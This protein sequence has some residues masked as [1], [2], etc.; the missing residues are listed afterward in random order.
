[1]DDNSG[2][3][4]TAI[5]DDRRRPSMPRAI[6]G[7]IQAGVLDAELTALISTMTEHGLPLVVA[8]ASDERSSGCT[9]HEISEAIGRALAAVALPATAGLGRPPVSIDA[10]SLESVL[11]RLP[12][13]AL[14]S[15]DDSGARV[16]VVVVLGIDP[17][18]GAWR[19]TAAHLLRPPLRDGQGHVQRQ[20]PAVLA[21]WDPERRRFEHFS[22]AVL[23]EVGQLVGC[24]AGDLEAEIAA[25]TDLL[26]GLAAHRVEDPG[27][28][29]LAL[30][31]ARLATAA[32]PQRH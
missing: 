30:E 15:V 21:T 10:D 5:A 29:R 28:V 19:L 22:W 14:E 3:P 27:A 24:R 23:A 1:V 20:G 25:R 4:G 6:T 26:A 32:A 16:A 7:W 12:T 11:V 17:L 13:L 31:A 8:A 18:D 2:Q 9:G